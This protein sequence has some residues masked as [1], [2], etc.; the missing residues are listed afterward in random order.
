MPHVVVEKPVMEGCGGGV[1]QKVYLASR[2]RD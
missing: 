2:H 1:H